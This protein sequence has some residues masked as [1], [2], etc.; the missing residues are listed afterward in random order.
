[1]DFLSPVVGTVTGIEVAM[2]KD[3]L[4]F[5]FKVIVFV[6]PFIVIGLFIEYDVGH[7]TVVNRMIKFG[8]VFL[9]FVPPFLFGILN[10]FAPGMP[11]TFW[12]SY[13]LIENFWIMEGK[14]APLLLSGLVLIYFLLYSLETVRGDLTN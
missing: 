9:F 2:W 11:E 3:I 7:V 10:Y 5:A 12:E 4:L 6:I 14:L 1:M 8:I 13:P